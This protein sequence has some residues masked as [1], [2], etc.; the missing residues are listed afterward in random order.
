[1]DLVVALRV[2]APS[3]EAVGSIAVSIEP[4]Q[5]GIKRMNQY[6]EQ[7]KGRANQINPAVLAGMKQSLGYQN[8]IIKGV[9]RETNFAR[10]LVEA[11]YR[12]K[13]IGLGLENTII[14]F[15]PWIVR[16]QA[17]ANANALQRWYFE[18]DYS[19]VVTNEDR[20]ALQ[21][22]GQGAKLT[23]EKEYL[24]K[25][26]TRSRGAGAGDAA[27]V[28][29]AKEFTQKFEALG[30]VMPVFSQMRNLFDMSIVAAFM[31]QNDFYGKANWDLG[32]FADEEKLTTKVNNGI[33]QVEPAV[34]AMWKEGTLI[35]PIGG[36]HIS[37]RKLASDPQVDSKLD[38]SSEK[39]SAPGD[40][41]QSQWWWD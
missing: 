12:M 16:T 20:S 22:K 1:M 23:S 7:F 36:V 37:S 39:L 10:V 30:E 35:T 38:E 11:D 3:T 19:S 26:G 21:L 33:S 4:T 31:Q 25:N 32:V 2:Y 5:E 40:L 34:N 15:T 41:A 13:L 28:G 17:G 9:P 24:A 29:F 14:P 18:A 8:V 6:N 27:S